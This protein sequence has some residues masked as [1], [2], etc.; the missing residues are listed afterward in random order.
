MIQ[1]DFECSEDQLLGRLVDLEM[2]KEKLL[3]SSALTSEL[4]D[5]IE[6]EQ[7][8]L[9]CYYHGSVNGREE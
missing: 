3:Y 6:Y 1:D 2:E 7:N 9:R 5:A 4:K 8:V